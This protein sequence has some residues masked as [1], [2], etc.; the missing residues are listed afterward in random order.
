MNDRI[1]RFLDGLSTIAASLFSKP[2][3]DPVQKVMFVVTG[4]GLYVFGLLRWAYFSNY[5]KISFQ[6][7]DWYQEHAYYSI[8]QSSLV[9]GTVPYHTN[10]LFHD[11]NRFLA[12]PELVFSPHVLLLSVVDSLGIFVLIHYLVLYS[13]GFLGCLAIQ[14][15][16]ELS[17]FS[18][19]VFFGLFTFNGYI[20]SHFAVGHTMWGGYFFIPFLLITLINITEH[21]GS[22]LRNA[23]A[24]AFTLFGIL[25]LGSIHV[26]AVCLL[27]LALFFVFNRRFLRVGLLTIPF[28]LVLNLYRFLPAVITY[29]NLDDPFL[30][31]YPTLLDILRSLVV[32]Q[33]PSMDLTAGLSSAL[34][35]WEMDV[36][37]GLIGLG[38]LLYFGVVRSWKQENPDLRFAEFDLPNAILVVFSVNNF[39][40]LIAHLPIP[41][42]GVERIPSRFLILPIIVLLLIATIRF[43]DELQRLGNLRRIHLIA[44]VCLVQLYLELMTHLRHWNVAAIDVN[45]PASE[46][47]EIHTVEVA[48]DLTYI[49]VFNASVAASAV[50][51]LICLAL[52][53]R[54][55]RTES[56]TADTR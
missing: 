36:Y 17:I 24:L 31:G 18:F 2:G 40:Y 19:S 22:D 34:N 29:R 43:D 32:I 42:A 56:A 53:I 27:Y 39:Y 44:A 45:L 16:F 46:L 51:T 7:A 35:W 37:I 8:L 47:L 12:L 9:T 3:A 28:A 54:A 33:R 49:W 13:I 6:T 26:A 23:L 30:S 20:T 15:R 5:G 41:F 14:R 55:R 50:G 10:Q 52:Y 11:S 21:R 1:S 25:L 38:F 4:A 48:N